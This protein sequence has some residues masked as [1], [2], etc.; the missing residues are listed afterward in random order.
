MGSP[1]HKSTGIAISQ[2]QDGRYQA[3][4]PW[5][6][7][8]G[9]T[10]RS[11]VY[12][13]TPAEVA[14]KVEQI[15]DRLK[16]QQP[17]NDSRALLDDYTALWLDSTLDGSDRKPATRRLY[18]NL[19]E[20]HIIGSAVGA[21]PL[22]KVLP[23]HVERWVANLRTAGLSQSTVRQTYIV[24][25]AIFDTA[26]RDQLLA[27]NP[28]AAVPRPRVAQHESEHLTA[29]QVARL[30][31]AAQS[32]RYGILFDFLA[33]TG[34]RRGEALA[35]RWQD[36]D[37]VRNTL[38]VRA[39]L[40]RVDGKLVRLPP[41]T[42]SSRRNVPLS[43]R[44]A[45]ILRNARQRQLADQKSVDPWW[46][47]TGFV[48]TT[49]AGEPCDPRNALRALKSAATH[50]GLPNVSL[51]TL[52]HTAATLMLLNNVPLKVVSEI[53]GHSSITITADIYGHV[54]HDA[55]R[56]ALTTLD[57]ALRPKASDRTP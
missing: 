41:K 49:E 26:V 34:L 44:A 24:L 54:T 27:S 29:E 17:V 37:L 2:R 53:L 20:K 47:D 15:K 38:Q 33:N 5:V 42:T 25:R 30:L 40:A 36:V 32:S 57:Q 51:H 6:D 48:F 31:D 11:Y 45:E 10:R 12:G 39:T 21:M 16:A 8:N 46:T 7:A 13:T 22:R 18:R 55:A 3:R 43:A 35:L 4:V 28:A 52:R 9:A 14:A 56:D 19:A 23:R 1:R 50:A